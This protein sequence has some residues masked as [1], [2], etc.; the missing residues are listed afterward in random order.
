MMQCVIYEIFQKKKKIYLTDQEIYT[1]HCVHFLKL[2]RHLICTVK[3]SNL[4]EVVTSGM[5]PAH[6]VC[7]KEDWRGPIMTDIAELQIEPNQNH[8]LKNLEGSIFAWLVGRC[9]LS[10]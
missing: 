5:T 10:R 6:V 8:L 7:G 9:C 4:A 3:T 2:Q 1:M